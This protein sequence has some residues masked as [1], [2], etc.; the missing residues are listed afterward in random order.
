MA[1][2]RSLIA[3]IHNP[4]N[5]FVGSSEPSRQFHPYWV[6]MAVLARTFGWSLAQTIAVGSYVSVTVLAC[7]FYTFG[8][9]YFRSPWGPLTLLLCSTLAWSIPIS[10]T[11]YINVPTLVEG[12]SYPAALL[13]GLSM[14]LWALIISSFEKP[15]LIV[16]IVPLAALMFSTHQLGAGLGFIVALAIASAWPVGQLR[17]RVAIFASMIVGVIASTFW[18]YFNPVEAVVRAGNPTWRN[19]IDFYTPYYLIGIFIPSAVGIA[20]LLRSR[21]GGRGR[22]LLLALIILLLGFVAGNRGFLVGTRFAPTAVLV[23]QI[24]IASILVPFFERPEE[25]SDRFKLTL[26]GSSFAF[27]LIQGLLLGLILYPFEDRSERRYGSVQ[28]AAT[29]LTSDIPDTQE[30]AAYDV[31]AWPVSAIGQKV[32]SIP[33]PEPFIKDLAI[34]QRKVE[35]LF[36]L[37]LSS[38]QRANLARRYSVR[39]LIL[40]ER[41]GPRGG[42]LRAW[43]PNELKRFETQSRKALK[44]GPMW[45]FDLY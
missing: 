33:W 17:Y 20:G 3:D 34:R 12:A 43:T 18:I 36:D 9:A 22:P 38:E 6:T 11:G 30:V 16:A 37:R 10:H 24:G 21:Y 1:A 28:R 35:E 23:L 5:P 4:T 19:G 39:T 8:R 26:V 2:L 25:F 13:V 45:R 40:D 14:M 29:T 31:A 15:K 7:G 44:A 42:D 27:L 32:L 41:Y